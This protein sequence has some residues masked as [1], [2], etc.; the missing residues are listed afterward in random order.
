MFL[1]RVGGASPLAAPRSSTRALCGTDSE[2]F[3]N[4]LHIC[5]KRMNLSHLPATGQQ[6]KASEEA[7]FVL[8]V[9]LCYYIADS[10]QDDGK[11]DNEN[12]SIVKSHLAL[13]IFI[14]K[15]ARKQTMLPIIP[16][17]I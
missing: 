13:Q 9:V 3:S 4:P 10:T 12:D 11:H 2:T 6:K 17:M 16:P 14:L 5:K 1:T 15:G 8:T 7:F